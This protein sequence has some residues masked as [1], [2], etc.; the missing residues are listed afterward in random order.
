MP[1]VAQPENPAVKSSIPRSIKNRPAPPAP[2]GE[3]Q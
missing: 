2:G 1:V 3:A